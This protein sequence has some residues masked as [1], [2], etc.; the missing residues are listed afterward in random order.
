M[1]RGHGTCT[2]FD[3]FCLSPELKERFRLACEAM[4]ISKSEV[5]RLFVQEWVNEVE[6]GAREAG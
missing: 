2:A 6:S 4:G 5:L 1:T 3:K